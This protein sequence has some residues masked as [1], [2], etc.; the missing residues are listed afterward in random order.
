MP[1]HFHLLI[2]EPEKRNVALVMQ[3]SKSR[4]KG[5]H[6]PVKMGELDCSGIRLTD[7]IG[8]V[9]ASKGHA[10]AAIEVPFSAWQ[11]AGYD[12]ASM[13]IWARPRWPSIPS[14]L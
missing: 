9:R 14:W 4:R 11:K 13:N 1:E 12:T 7:G 6:P 2:S 5:G 10:A 8:P 3:E